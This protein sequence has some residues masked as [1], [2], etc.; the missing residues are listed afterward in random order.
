MREKSIR[1]GVL[2]ISDSLSHG[3]KPISDD[4]SGP[5]VIEMVSNFF[6]KIFWSFSTSTGLIDD[7][8]ENIKQIL[9]EWTDKKCLELIFTTGGTGFS[10][11][12]NAP[13]ATREIIQRETPGIT[14]AMFSESWKK[15]PHA[16]L[17]RAIS[18]I[19]GRTLIVNLPG[20]PRAV[21]EILSVLLP[22]L[23]HGLDLLREDQEAS[24]QSSHQTVVSQLPASIKPSKAIENTND[25]TKTSCHSHSHHP[26]DGA[27]R[28]K[29]PWPMIP[30]PEALSIVFQ[31]AWILPDC[32]VSLERSL[33]CISAQDIKAKEPIPP[34]PASVKDGYAV[35]AEDGPGIYPV[36]GVATAGSI[37]SWT[38]N[39]GKIARITTGAPVPQGANAVIQVEDTVLHPGKE[40]NSQEFVEILSSVRVGQDIRPIGSDIAEG[41][42][43]VRLGDRIGPSEIGLLASVGKYLLVFFCS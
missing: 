22:A 32:T 16:I 14:M 4:L 41:E 18:G 11:R 43:V 42:T 40:Q 33:G 31:H 8:K 5:K 30:I 38:L 15:T 27:V 36:I 1:F 23:P 35:I 2:T 20:S 34:F 10:K 26:Q 9:L 12:D 7:E 37:P 29:S 6:K 21:E 13:E 39:S 28:R 19:R 24:K 17:S 25:H 3:E